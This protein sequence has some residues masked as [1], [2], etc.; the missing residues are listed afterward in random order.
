M[1][2]GS[3]T[4]KIVLPLGAMVLL[5]Q[6]GL[7][8]F[9]LDHEHRALLDQLDARAAR[10][11]NICTAFNLRDEQLS[12]EQVAQWLGATLMEQADVVFCEVTLTGDES[13]FRQGSI[14]ESHSRRYA[15][16]FPVVNKPSIDT[17]APG[18]TLYLGLST[19]KIEQALTEMRGALAVSVLAGTALVILL[20][21]LVIRH[22]I[23][24]TLARLLRRA[25]T[26]PVRQVEIAAAT[27][28]RDELEQLTEIVD[29]ITA[30]L[31]EV[32]TRQEQL[33]A[34]SIAE[35]QS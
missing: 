33:T 6:V 17:T 1:S 4:Q 8:A 31:R 26:A 32:V 15:F 10:L 28:S 20:S 18:G 27:R 24:K 35:T 5:L 11:A 29:A 16:D 30:E 34:E 25:R 19:A 9:A 12:Q 22:V 14:E 3:L 2:R 7:S 23:G 21:T 13:L